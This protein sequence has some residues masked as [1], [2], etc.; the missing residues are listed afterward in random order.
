V[1]GLNGLA[2]RGLRARPLRTGLTVA[3]VALG[4]AV[5]FA[6]LATNAGIDAAVDRAVGTLVGNADLRVAAFGEVGLSNETLD[7]VAAT[8]GV[9]VVAPS[10][11]RR[12]YHSAKLFEPGD[13]LPPPVTIAGIDPTAEAKLHDLTLAAGPGLVTPGPD[14]A[15]VSATLARED[16]ITLG[17]TIGLSTIDAPVYLRVVG[18]M[19]GDGPWSGAGGRAVVLRLE[20]A[21]RIFEADGLTRIDVG[22]QDGASATAVTDALQSTL[23]GEPYVL[24]SPRDVGAA[25]RASTGDFAAT[26][27]LIGAIALF[28]GAFLIFNS[29][30]MTV[31]ERVRELGLLR[32][33]GASR[34]QLT[35]YIL[36]Q[37]TAI[38]IV[39]SVLGIGL[40]A[41]LASGIAAWV[42]TVGSVPLGAPVVAGGDA[43][44]AVVIGIVVTLAAAIEPARRA[45]RISPVEALKARMDL[46]TARRARLR[47]LIAV[48]ALVG[49]AGLLIWPRGAGQAALLRA[50]L[51][52]GV[53][54]VVAL[55]VPFVLPAIARVA[56]VPFGLLTRFEERLARASLLR[57]RSRA[58]L[59]VGALTV[60]LAM[61]V[62]LGGVG[63]NARAAAGAWVA[64][65]VPGDL[66]L[67]SIFPRGLDELDDVFAAPAVVDPVVVD[68]AA[69]EPADVAP[70]LAIASIS[71]IGTFGLA[72]DGNPTDGV[73]M[74]GADLEADGRL[75]FVAGDRAAALAALDQGGAV[76]VP[77]GIAQR[78]G[79]DLDATIDA[80]AADGSVLPL[81][82]V[83]I[84]ERTLPGPT[85]E[86]LIVGWS[87]AGLLGVVGADAFAV[88]FRPTATAADRAELADVA[89]SL[90]LEPTALG[91]IEGAIGQALDRV[92]GLFDVLALVAIVVA[93]LGIVNT[94]TMNV[95]ERVREI[96]VLRA[97]GMTRRQVWRSVVVEA[98]ITGL[99][100][101]ICGVG[102]GILIGGLMVVLAGGRWDVA[103]AVP[104][105]AVGAAFGLGVVLSMLAAAYPARLASGVSIVRAVG[106]E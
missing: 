103:T 17:T 52:Y 24:S 51:V 15:L 99:V 3:G 66:V 20:T 95:L 32:A 49:V 21:Q 30:S 6:G 25:M 70:D 34:A 96:G 63:Q 36:V 7:L 27:A 35:S 11:E 60:G 53:L 100:G 98:G 88:R 1:R 31:V 105:P 48:F 94:L 33:A 2:W 73:A 77:A 106:Y 76:I 83:G 44:T 93:A 37:A 28:A 101:A 19:N 81:R 47:W 65:V 5:L 80:T 38:G 72:I 26:T 75:R 40:G 8:D 102:A 68:P 85:G 9:A 69:T 46:P 58:A 59:T 57:D 16:G 62:A 12:T 50:F 4:V 56:G 82:V 92:F 14:D 18:I 79:L 55:I 78:D 71:P 42:R 22:L 84:A 61:I 91:H 43:L 39:G 10:F 89:R 54:L 86:S 90:A 97:A 104:W 64:D 29:L 74:V 41:A 67:T 23:L 13:A 45:G 87:D